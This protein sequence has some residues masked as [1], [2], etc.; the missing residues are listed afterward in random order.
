MQV[1]SNSGRNQVRLTNVSVVRLRK[2][3]KRFEVAAYKNKVVNWRSG[4]ETDLANV[5]QIAS[6][7]M[8]VSRG[9]RA[10]AA[11]LLAAFGT[12]DALACARMILEKG[13]L[14]KGELERTSEL[15]GMFRDIASCVAERCVNP[16]TQRPYP[17]AFVEAAMRDA[18]FSVSAGKSAKQQALKA[19]GAL[20]EHIPIERAKMALR[21][22]V[23]SKGAG[24]ARRFLNALSMELITSEMSIVPGGDAAA[25]EGDVTSFDLLA[26]PGFFKSIEEGECGVRGG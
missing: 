5:L 26:E 23:P 24:A 16:N 11:D 17:V 20:R 7:F 13:E 4:A 6:V 12:D 15:D 18:G 19:I 22:N 10:T 8:N 21:V 9:V 14:E 3:G 2:G 25:S 1:V